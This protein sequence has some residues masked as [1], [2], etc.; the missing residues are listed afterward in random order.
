LNEINDIEYI[1]GRSY[2]IMPMCFYCNEI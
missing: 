1:K 2:I